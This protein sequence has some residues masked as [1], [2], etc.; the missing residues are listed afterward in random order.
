MKRLLFVVG[1]LLLPLAACG[2]TSTTASSSPSV[3]PSQA[4]ASPS[5]ASSPSATPLPA[6][7]I[8][9]TIAFTRVIDPSVGGNGDIYVVKSDG[10]GLKQLTDDPGFEERPQWSPDGR[11]IAYG[12]YPAGFT[13]P[14]D[15]SVWIMNADGS[16]KAR[17]TKGAVKGIYPSWSLDGKQI[18]FV[19]P[20]ADGYRIFVM[21]SDGSGLERVTRPPGGGMPGIAVNDLFPAW[22][23][24]GRILFMRLGQ[25]FAVNIDGS[26]LRQVTKGE[27]IAE[28]AVSPDGKRLALYYNNKDSVVVLP[29]NGGG[30]SVKVLE[31]VSDFILSGHFPAPAWTPDGQA[32]VVGTSSWAE[33]GTHVGS[34]RLYV[35]NADGSGL[36]AV[37]GV[38]N[39][40]D[41]AW[42]P[43]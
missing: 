13:G 32:L 5:V 35:V 6:P 3:A 43:E 1:C 2:G 8:T 15:A 37:P 28:F 17:L 4:A 16:G 31:P 11:K 42:R 21:N 24:G 26:G 14:E 29:T 22:V 25:V 18:A 9:G 38:D 23:P 27:N 12:G 39:E 40:I 20:F 19:R 10:T 36:S 7:T 41:P 33:E 34:S 30:N